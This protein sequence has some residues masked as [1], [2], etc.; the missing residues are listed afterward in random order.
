MAFLLAGPLLGAMVKKVL[1]KVEG[2][3][4]LRRSYL[5]CG[6]LAALLCGALILG[7]LLAVRARRQ[8]D[9]RQRDR[10]HT[11]GGR[12]GFSPFS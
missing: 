3:G 6:G 5:L 1:P 2:A 4:K 9:R 11:L 7:Q 8:R 12:M 10:I